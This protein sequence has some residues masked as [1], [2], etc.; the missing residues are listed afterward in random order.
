MMKIHVPTVSLQ[1]LPSS[2]SASLVEEA[3]VAV[4]IFPNLLRQPAFVGRLTCPG[5]GH[6]GLRGG[7]AE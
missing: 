6:R 3:G 2:D 7:P 1:R 4:Q 5:G